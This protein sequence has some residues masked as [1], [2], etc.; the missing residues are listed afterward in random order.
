MLEIRDL[1]KPGD[2]TLLHRKFKNL[3]KLVERDLTKDFDFD[4]SLMYTILSNLG[5]NV[6]VSS[7]I[8]YGTVLKIKFSLWNF[9]P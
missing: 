2:Q 3:D 8:S 6:E 5:G 7:S 4:S 1:A 9:L